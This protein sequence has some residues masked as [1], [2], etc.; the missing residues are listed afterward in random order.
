M[1]PD[2][3]IKTASIRKADSN[4]FYSLV[5]RDYSLEKNY[6]FLLYSIYLFIA[7]N[8]FIPPPSLKKSLFF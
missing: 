1:T 6:Y 4:N 7:L 3:D 2:K 8:Y 5:G